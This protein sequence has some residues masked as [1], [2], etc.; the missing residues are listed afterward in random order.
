MYGWD[1]QNDRMSLSC[2]GLMGALNVIGA[3]TY[4]LRI[5][6]RWVPLRH[7]VYGSSHQILHVVVVLA[8]LTHMV[9][10]LNAFDHIHS[11]ISPPCI[12]R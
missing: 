10:L 6:E 7:D 9:G 11:H 2:M 8:G 12:L 3:I 5:P 4:A 1:I